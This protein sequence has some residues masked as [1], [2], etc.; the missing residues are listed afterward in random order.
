MPLNRIFALIPAA[1]VGARMASDVPKQYLPLHGKPMLAHALGTLAGCVQ[2]EQVFV[3][4]GSDDGWIDEALTHVGGR[5]ERLT[6]LR[7]GGATRQQTVLNGLAAMRCMVRDDDRVLVHDAAR[8][9]LTEAML[10][11]LIDEVADDPAGGLLA[12]PMV[13]TVK[14]ASDGRSSRTVPRERLWAA[15]TPQ[16]FP[17]RLLRQALEQASSVTDEASAV[18]QLGLQPRLVLGSARNLKVT[19]PGDLAMAEFL[20]RGT[21]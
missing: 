17:Y 5:Q 11:R 13:D 12:M 10:V 8:P 3:V 1:G 16:L 19:L 20:M 15:Q 21:E 4:V 9:G 14:E 7:Q 6:I 2:I 18:E